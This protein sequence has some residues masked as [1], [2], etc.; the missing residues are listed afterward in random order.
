MFLYKILI[1]VFIF[2]SITSQCVNG[3]GNPV[4]SYDCLK[5]A[6]NS[7]N[8]CC[9][10]SS[11]GYNPTNQM[12][13]LL[14]VSSYVGQDSYLYGNLTYKIDCGSPYVTPVKAGPCGNTNPLH[15]ADCWMF[16]NYDSS[17]CYYKSENTTGTPGCQ[18]LGKKTTGKVLNDALIELNCSSTFNKIRLIILLLALVFII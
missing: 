3:G 9:M 18:W 6:D 8:Y 4:S 15:S 10:L 16:S 2:N 13:I 1:L 5:N 17:C 12:C 14:P 11:P 7:T